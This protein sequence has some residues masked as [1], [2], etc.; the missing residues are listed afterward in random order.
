MPCCCRRPC[1]C[2]VPVT[3]IL[4]VI[5]FCYLL[6]GAA[7]FSA[8]ESPA[9]QKMTLNLLQEKWSLLQNHTCMDN[10][11]LEMFIAGIIK[12]YKSGI[13]L[14][15]NNTDQETWNFPG[16]FFFSVT[17]ITTIGYG[18][19]S[20]STMGGQI[21]CVFF[22]L[23]GIPLNLILLNRIGEKMLRLVQRSAEY[24]GRKIGRQKTVKFLF[25]SCALV[26]GLLFFFL[27]PPILFRGME[28]WSYEEGFYYSFIT[29]STIGFGDYVIGQD[30]NVN[31]PYWYM[32][33]VSMWI[34]FGMA[35]LALIITL[36]VNLLQKTRDLCL[37]PKRI[38]DKT[39]ELNGL[40][41]TSQEAE[42]AES[43]TSISKA[44]SQESV[45]SNGE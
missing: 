15:G 12:A 13:I 30:P 31:Y 43:R 25:S 20:P 29:L 40:A 38:E 24:L 26:I 17:V 5:Y 3:L 10:Q 14:L 37:C 4:L 7:V 35:W 23:F 42:D 44:E 9:E 41:P 34:L 33:L 39:K 19:R 2:R 8:L 21:F 18:N 22:A 36:S 27:L 45:Q 11:T 16:S 32:N 1:R 28:G 6:V